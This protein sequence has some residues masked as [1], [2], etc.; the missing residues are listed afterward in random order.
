MGQADNTSTEGAGAVPD[1]WAPALAELGRRRAAAHAMGGF[2]KE[3]AAAAIELPANHVIHAMVAIG[4]RGDPQ[5]LPEPL[6]GRETPTPRKPL[7][8]TTFHGTFP[9]SK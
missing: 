6:R 2:E 5:S 4:K 3:V 9:P 8:E 1:E 7:A